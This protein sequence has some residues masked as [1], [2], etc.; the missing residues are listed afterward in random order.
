MTRRDDDP[1][2]RVSGEQVSQRGGGDPHKETHPVPAP[3][4]QKHS[5][6]SPNTK[7]PA[8]QE[9]GGIAEAEELHQVTPE[10]REPDPS[11]IVPESESDSQAHQRLGADSTAQEKSLSRSGS[12]TSTGTYRVEKPKKSLPLSKSSQNGTPRSHK[13]PDPKRSNSD[14]S[15]TDC[16]STGT[17][18]VESSKVSKN[19]SCT[20]K[21]DA[22]KS[23]KSSK[24]KSVSRET[25]SESSEKRRKHTASPSAASK[26][27]TQPEPTQVRERVTP[28]NP[29]EGPGTS[30][31][32]TGDPPPPHHMVTI[33]RVYELCVYCYRN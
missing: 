16:S 23:L 6:L 22:P 14:D 21:T 4:S 15:S 32:H 11:N 1:G 30:Y 27:P 5:P 2:Q 7:S 25:S 9:T 19:V 3:R 33:I 10:C 13:S 17:Y 26:K 29:E 8:L 28:E 31:S 12:D 24:S 18:N 20:S